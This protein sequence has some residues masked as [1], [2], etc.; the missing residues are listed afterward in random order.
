MCFDGSISGNICESLQIK[1]F[2]WIKMIIVAF[3]KKN[4]IT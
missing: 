1:T 2:K 4:L 3:V